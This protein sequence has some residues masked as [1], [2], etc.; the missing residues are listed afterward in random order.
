MYRVSAIFGSQRTVR[1]ILTSALPDFDTEFTKE[2]PT[3]TPVQ[4]QLSAADQAEFAGFS[5]VSLIDV[6]PCH[7]IDQA[8]LVD[9]TM[10]QLDGRIRV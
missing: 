7:R 1:Q 4:Q 2:K 9:R 5:W 3:L 6:R 8:L 10:G